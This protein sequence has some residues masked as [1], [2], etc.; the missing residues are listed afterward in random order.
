VNGFDEVR[1]YE[2]EMFEGRASFVSVPQDHSEEFRLFDVINFRSDT[3]VL[4]MNR[5]IQ[6]YYQISC[7]RICPLLL[8]SLGHVASYHKEAKLSRDIFDEACL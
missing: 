3:T 7:C 5:R 1:R 2:V 4:E 8:E 6:T